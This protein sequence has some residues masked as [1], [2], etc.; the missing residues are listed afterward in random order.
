MVL[1]SRRTSPKAPGCLLG[2]QGP[3]PITSLPGVY[4]SEAESWLNRLWPDPDYDV[5]PRVQLRR[6]RGGS[7]AKA[8]PVMRP[9]LD[10]GLP[11]PKA[12]LSPLLLDLMGWPVSTTPTAMSSG[13]D[14]TAPH[15]STYPCTVHPPPTQPPVTLSVHM[16]TPL[17]PT[18]DSLCFSSQPIHTRWVCQPAAEPHPLGGRC[19]WWAEEDPGVLGPGAGRGGPSPPLASPPTHTHGRRP[20]WCMPPQL[21]GAAL[22]STAPAAG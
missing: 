19:A 4:V 11:D 20:R 7:L 2:S 18:Q 6:L 14:V 22:G 12:G 17:K 1:G 5:S 13:Q 8:T 16:P 3:P 15:S 10:S 21:S 9:R